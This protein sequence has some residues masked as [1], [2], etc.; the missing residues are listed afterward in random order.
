MTKTLLFGRLITSIPVVV[1]AG[2]GGCAMPNSSNPTLSIREARVS[3]NRALLEMQVD[4]PSEMDV[5]IESG[6]WTLLYGPLPVAKGTW[7]LGVLVPSGGSYRFERDI[8]FSSAPL[9]PNADEVEL[10]GTFDI[11]TVGNSSDTALH[12]GSFAASKTIVR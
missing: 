6:D 9:D 1:L 10:N 8:Q 4:N 5:R 12:G 11:Q 2:I 7:E 3:G